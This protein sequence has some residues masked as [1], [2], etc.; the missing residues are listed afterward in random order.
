LFPK[1]DFGNDVT[2]VIKDLHGLF[3]RLMLAGIRKQ[4]DLE[5]GLHIEKLSHKK[6]STFA[7]L[8]REPGF[9]PALNAGASSAGEMV[10]LNTSKTR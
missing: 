1:G 10:I 2:G 4:F 8:S 6:D 5:R 9:L 7:N 3:Q